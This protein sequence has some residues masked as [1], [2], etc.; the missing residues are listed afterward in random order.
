MN[1]LRLRC[2]GEYQ[3]PPLLKRRCNM[4]YK[5]KKI[6]TD[7]MLLTMTLTAN[8]IVLFETVMFSMRTIRCQSTKSILPTTRNMTLS[9]RLV[10]HLEMVCP[11]TEICQT[12]QLLSLYLKLR[13][14]LTIRSLPS[15]KKTFMRSL[16]S[17]Y[18][19][20]QDKKCFQMKFSLILI[21]AKRSLPSKTN[22]WDLR[23]Y[24]SSN[25]LRFSFEKIPFSR[26]VFL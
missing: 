5:W 23:I 25:S 14:K 18:I 9:H 21:Q 13:L 20:L 7:I 2:A 6:Q 12:Q 17:H 4:V 15:R 24:Q 8:I 22:A 11:R 3:P 16:L 1:S 26:Q 10:I 19:I